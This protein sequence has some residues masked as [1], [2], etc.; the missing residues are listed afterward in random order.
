M[1]THSSILAWRIPWTEEPGGLQSIGS[2]RVRQDWSNLAS[3][4]HVKCWDYNSEQ[5]K[6]PAFMKFCPSS[7]YQLNI[8]P[9]RRS[10]WPLIFLRCISPGLIMATLYL[11]IFHNLSFLQNRQWHPTPVLLP[12]KSHGWRSLVGFSPWGCEESDTTERLHFHSS[13]SWIGEG[14]GNPLQCS[15]LE[16][17][18]DSRAWWAAVYGVAQ[19]RTQL[20][21]LSSLAAEYLDVW[22]SYKTNVSNLLLKHH[23]SFNTTTIFTAFQNYSNIWWASSQQRES[24]F[25]SRTK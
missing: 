4:H 13:L 5:D 12:G 6:V 14:N 25:H 17:P 19:S 24:N 15:C 20:K 10:L 21:Q 9:L 18:S 7:Y 16:N 3:K 11:K 22:I 1:A 8:W 23:S 2:Q